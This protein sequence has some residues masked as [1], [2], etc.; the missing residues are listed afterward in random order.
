MDCSI[1]VS[2]IHIWH[3]WRAASRFSRRH[4]CSL[5]P[6]QAEAAATAAVNMKWTQTW[7]HDIFRDQDLKEDTMS[8]QNPQSMIKKLVPT[9]RFLKQ[10]SPEKW[11]HECRNT[12]HKCTNINTQTSNTHTEILIQKHKYQKLTVSQIDFSEKVRSWMNFLP[13]AIGPKNLTKD[14]FV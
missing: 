5:R 14:Q 2:C 8:T 11:D 1:L 4:Y 7:F 12:T 3:F 9:W 10:T 6:N 13:Q